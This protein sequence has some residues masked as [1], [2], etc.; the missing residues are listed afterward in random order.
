VLGPQGTV[1]EGTKLG[2]PP[3]FLDAQTLAVAA[4]LVSLGTHPYLLT[5]LGLALTG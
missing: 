1:T 2:F 5:L 4:L 3:G